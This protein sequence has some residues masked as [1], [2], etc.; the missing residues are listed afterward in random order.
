[1]DVLEFREKI[2][3]DSR[4]EIDG[5][6]FVVRQIVKFRLDD[7]SIYLKLFLND[8]YVFA[9]DSNENIYILVHE[10]KTNFLTPFPLELDYI[11]K[12]FKF[13]YSA[14][15]NAEETLGQ[16]IFKQ[17]DSESFSD[18]KADDGGYLS[19]GV[20]DNSKIRL[21]FYGKIIASDKVKIK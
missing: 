8:G 11:E 13:S 10:V 2:K 5:K 15:A 7:S 4:L 12:H 18:Y 1:M 21:D 9:D 20:I 16:E 6:E 17:G 19:L 14:H 3:L